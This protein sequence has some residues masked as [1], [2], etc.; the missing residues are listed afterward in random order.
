MEYE[1]RKAILISARPAVRISGRRLKLKA[2]LTLHNMTS[3]GNHL[4]I[5]FL[6]KPSS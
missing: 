4:S 5:V 1:A 6:G 3:S 2:K